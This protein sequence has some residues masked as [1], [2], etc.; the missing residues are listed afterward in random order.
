MEKTRVVYLCRL[1]RA[2]QKHEY[3]KVCVSLIKELGITIKEIEAV[4]LSY[5]HNIDDI[6][7]LREKT[8]KAVV[9]NLRLKLVYHGLKEGILQI[10]K[11]LPKVTFWNDRILVG[12]SENGM[13]KIKSAKNGVS[14]TAIDPFGSAEFIKMLE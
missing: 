13:L 12:I 2:T 1:L 11:P 5:A 3:Y 6:K 4:K 10:G 9:T 14:T 8:M 7:K